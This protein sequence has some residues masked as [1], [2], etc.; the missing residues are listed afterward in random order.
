MLILSIDD[1]MVNQVV[2]ESVL[3]KYGHVVKRIMGGQA[4]LEYLEEMGI[5]TI[6]AI[7]LDV[8]MPVMN[9]Y[10]VLQKIREKYATVPVPIL[11]ISAKKQVRLF[12]RTRTDSKR[13]ERFCLRDFADPMQQLG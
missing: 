9:G 10:E 1:N 13:S 6:D 4:C 8:C 5:H 2:V 3:E 12:S 11:M 7:L